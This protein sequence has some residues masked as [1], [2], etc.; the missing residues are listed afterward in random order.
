MSKSRK[1]RDGKMYSVKRMKRGAK[2]SSCKGEYV[3]AM[4]VHA[5][6]RKTRLRDVLHEESMGIARSEP[7]GTA[8]G[9]RSAESDIFG[10]VQGEDGS[11]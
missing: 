2:A 11:D 6:E 9:A 1:T 7:S 3:A 8:S 10:F 5:R 4:V